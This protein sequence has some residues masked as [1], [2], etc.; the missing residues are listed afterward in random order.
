MKVRKTI[1]ISTTQHKPCSRTIMD[2]EIRNKVIE[3]GIRVLKQIHLNMYQYQVSYYIYRWELC[4]FIAFQVIYAYISIIFVIILYVLYFPLSIT[5]ISKVPGSS[6]TPIKM[7]RLQFVDLNWYWCVICLLV[8]PRYFIK[9]HYIDI[10]TSP[11]K[12]DIR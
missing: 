8:L 1:V 2:E 5:I 7:D 12:I 4:C 6:T 9:L 10:L 3:I 11:L